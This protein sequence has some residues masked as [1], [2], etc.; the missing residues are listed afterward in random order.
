MKKTVFILILVTI[1]LIGYSTLP[2]KMGY[3]APSVEGF[4]DVPTTHWIYPLI[5]ELKNANKI[6]TEKTFK[7]GSG[8]T[9]NDIVNYLKVMYPNKSFDKTYD[10][11]KNL[12][13]HSALKS[14]FSLLEYESLYL[15]N[16]TLT[17][18]FTDTSDESAMY[19]VAVDLKWITVNNTQLFRP[20]DLIKK[21]EFIAILYNVHK[22]DSYKLKEL[23]SYYAINSY[24]Q[25]K[26][27]QA[28]DTLY[29]GWSRLELN[30]DKSSVV[31]NSTSSNS[32]EY[33]VPTGY[34]EV[35]RS[36]NDVQA[37][38]PLMIFVKDELYQTALNQS[39]TSAILA[40]EKLKNAA[41]ESIKAAVTTNSYA[42]QYSGVLIDF[43]GLKGKEQAEQLNIFI[44]ELAT[45]LDEVEMTLSVV[46]HPQRRSVTTY[47]DG[48]DYRTLSKYADYLILMA[49]D[50][51][52]KS[53]TDSEMKLKQTL[54]PLTPINEVYYALSKITDSK[55]GVEDPSKV[56]LQLSMD[57]VQWKIQNDTVV[58]KQP[59]HPTYA[60][61]K[62]RIE[63]GV[64]PQY[65]KSLESPY[66]T[67]YDPEDETDNVV[68]YEDVKS[69]QA[70]IDLGKYFRIGGISVWRL[71]IIPDLDL[72]DLNLWKQIQTN[73]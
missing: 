65:S 26:Y 37:K 4:T 68:W 73:F 25:I 58:N 53:L 11:T 42:I 28:L 21:E 5:V 47:F 31:L 59:Y 52:P 48:Y 32:N 45:Y 51:Y 2:I 35:T 7:L 23:Q 1:L 66:L 14:L 34:T 43:E 56:I 39:L 64:Q 13:R 72:N 19:R 3:S 60:A 57:S 15:Q 20:N 22:G 67:Y 54:T 18:P 17:S 6:E 38:I 70:K 9:E 62:K 30:R 50:Y 49:H 40:N 69:I 36:A 41:L 33:K 44:R 8:L 10:K 71:G 61:I 55:T 27:I 16:K 12:T 46:V 24:N 29:L 63:S